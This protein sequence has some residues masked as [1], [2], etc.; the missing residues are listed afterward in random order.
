MIDL[1]NSLYDEILAIKDD[2]NE[3]ETIENS[4]EKQHQIYD[5]LWKVMVSHKFHIADYLQLDKLKRNC[6]ARIQNVLK[7]WVSKYQERYY[8]K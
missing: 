5:R 1:E 2:Y 4:L 6:E 3:E 8:M 7:A